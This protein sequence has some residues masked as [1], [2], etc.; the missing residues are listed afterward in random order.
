MASIA[1]R[2]AIGHVHINRRWVVMLLVALVCI[3]SA[4]IMAPGRST[5]VNERT[6][7]TGNAG[8]IGSSATC[9]HTVVLPRRGLLC[10]EST[11]GNSNISPGSGAADRLPS[12]TK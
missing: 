6:E 2:Q 11:R 10:L 8:Y 12:P 3:M 7:V 4:A 1:K 5:M 9:H